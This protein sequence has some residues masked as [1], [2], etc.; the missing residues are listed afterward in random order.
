M[1]CPRCKNQMD[2]IQDPD[3]SFEKCS[4]C[5]GTFLDRSELDQLATGMA[6]AIEFC[7]T[8]EGPEGA[9]YRFPI[10]SCPKCIEPEMIKTV[11]LGYSTV[12]FD[13]CPQCKGFFLDRGEIKEMNAYLTELDRSGSKTEFRGMRGNQFVTIHQIETTELVSG[14]LMPRVVSRVFT[15][16][17]VWFKKPFGHGIRIGKETLGTKLAKLFGR[18]DLHTGHDEFD[19]QFLVQGDHPKEIL[20]VLSLEIRNGLLALS[21]NPALKKGSLELLDHGATY[22]EEGRGIQPES[23]KEEILDALGTF[24]ARIDENAEKAS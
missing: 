18:K 23:R 16:L 24:A 5:G 22:R 3:I 9:T 4:R 6:G 13:H 1:K 11:L 7:S 20:E 17:A 10:S 14:V 8:K 12:I 15:Q 19:K 2:V 21:R